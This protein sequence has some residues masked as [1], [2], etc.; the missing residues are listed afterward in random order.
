MYQFALSVQS[1]EASDSN[2]VSAQMLGS[3]AFASHT[4]AVA[5]FGHF[6]A[7]SKPEFSGRGLPVN[8]KDQVPCFSVG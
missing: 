4:A 2:A 5:P 3:R 6:S 1:S 8:Q 7:L